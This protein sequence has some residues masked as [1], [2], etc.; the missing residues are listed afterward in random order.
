[1]HESSWHNISVLSDST[2]LYYHAT[3]KDFVASVDT[4]VS[5]DYLSAFTLTHYPLHEV[6]SS[7]V[8]IIF[9]FVPLQHAK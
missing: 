5:I 9:V 4:T 1:M 3:M 8:C 6:V 7:R 2:Q